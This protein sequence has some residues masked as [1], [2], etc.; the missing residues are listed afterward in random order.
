MVQSI[1]NP[2]PDVSNRSCL[3]NMLAG[4]TVEYPLWRGK[5]CEIRHHAGLSYLIEKQCLP[6]AVKIARCL[7]P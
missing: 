5:S 6:E 2:W 3:E 7:R 4:V 1:S